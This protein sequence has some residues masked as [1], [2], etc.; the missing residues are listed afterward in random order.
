[1]WQRIQTLYLLIASALLGLMY[2][3]QFRTA[4]IVLSSIALALQLLAL[5]TYKLRA[6]Q[7]RLSTLAALILIGL[8]IWMAVDFFTDSPRPEM[9]LS[10]IFPIVAAILDGLALRGILA[11]EFLVRSAS[12][13]R[14]SKRK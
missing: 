7:L 8:Q 11:D 9:H 12:R 13:L 6:L 10:Q 14:S 4:Y 5:L 2:F 3:D 1:M